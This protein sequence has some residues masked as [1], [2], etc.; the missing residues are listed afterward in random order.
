MAP[1]AGF[2][3]VL[4]TSSHA[5]CAWL[6]ALLIIAGV[7]TPMVGAEPVSNHKKKTSMGGSLIDQLGIAYDYRA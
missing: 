1:T 5:H 7:P 2:V 4:N 6:R 3:S